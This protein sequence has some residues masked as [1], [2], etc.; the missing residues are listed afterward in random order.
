[1]AKR[2]QAPKSN[3]EQPWR[4]LA[5][6]KAVLEFRDCLGSFAEQQSVPA[7]AQ[8]PRLVISS[9]MDDECREAFDGM[10]RKMFRQYGK[11]RFGKLSGQ[12]ISQV[13]VPTVVRHTRIEGDSQRIASDD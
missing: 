12:L 4:E 9:A 8:A 10:A 7:T 5:R 6:N 13:F 11:D 2:R 1:M 3:V